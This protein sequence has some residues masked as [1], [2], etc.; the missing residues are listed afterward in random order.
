MD[1]VSA[2]RHYLIKWDQHISSTALLAYTQKGLCLDCSGI[3]LESAL[4]ILSSPVLSD[5]QPAWQWNQQDLLKWCG[6]GTLGGNSKLVSAGS[7][8]TVSPTADR[9]GQEG[10][11]LVPSTTWGR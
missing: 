1:F 5:L 11:G 6:L 4:L 2:F 8:L 9:A 7:P 3:T 10:M